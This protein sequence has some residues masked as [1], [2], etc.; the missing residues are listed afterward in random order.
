M[1]GA[2]ERTD[3]GLR[4]DDDSIQSPILGAGTFVRSELAYVVPF[5]VPCGHCE[6]E[7]FEFVAQLVDREELVCQEC[8]T[9]LDLN[10]KE[11]AS[12]RNKL[13]KLCVQ[14]LAPVARIK[15]AP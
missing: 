15:M 13:R 12:L 10:A 5:P 9:T 14:K 6:R 8:G 3:V 2:T 7:T 11:W 1:P 4:L